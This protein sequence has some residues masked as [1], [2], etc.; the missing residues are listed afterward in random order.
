LAKRIAKNNGVDLSQIQGSGPRGRIVKVDVETYK[1][2]SAQVSAGPA[3]VDQPLSSVRK[4]IAKRLTESKQNIPHFYLTVTCNVDKLLDF[5]AQINTALAPVKISVNDIIIKA[6]AAALA[7][8][9]EANVM[10]M[11]N[12]LRVYNTVDIAVAV[13]IDGGLL[14]PIV[15]N[16]Q[17]KSL[18]EISL[19]I[20]ELAQRARDGKLKPEEYQGGSMTISNLGMYGIDE[21]CAIINPPQS[22]ILAIGKATEQAISQNGKIVSASIMTATLSVDHR[23]IDG[24][25]GAQLICD[26]KHFVENPLSLLV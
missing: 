6:F 25:V 10:W 17:N 2:K 1:P 26:F 15:Q 7:K 8:N 11:D 20:K 13:A 24:A 12:A 14:T 22:G 18:K 21:F 4:I 16:A 19:E 23:A 9:K 5:R 3:Y